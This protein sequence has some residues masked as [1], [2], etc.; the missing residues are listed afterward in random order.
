MRRARR[1][2]GSDPLSST[3]PDGR[4]GTTLPPRRPPLTPRWAALGADCARE[5]SCR[6]SPT[7]S[8]A[9]CW[10]TSSS[11]SSAPNA[12]PARPREATCRAGVD[13]E[14]LSGWSGCLS[15]GS[16]RSWGLRVS[17][18]ALAGSVRRRPR[19]RRALVTSCAGSV[20]FAAPARGRCCT[21]PSAKTC[22][23]LAVTAVEGPGGAEAEQTALRPGD[24]LRAFRPHP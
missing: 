10:R 15:H 7:F 19:R 23:A 11:S 14:P 4:R 1:N 3:G 21:K 24:D 6:Q 13:Q 18:R 2:P 20:V 8:V 17:R 16:P 5:D 12:A 22:A 9:G